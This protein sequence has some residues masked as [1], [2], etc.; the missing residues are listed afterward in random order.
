VRVIHNCCSS[1]DD[2]DQHV[3]KGDV[4]LPEALHARPDLLDV[5][6]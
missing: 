5:G 4:E 1:A 3:L 6:R 2:L